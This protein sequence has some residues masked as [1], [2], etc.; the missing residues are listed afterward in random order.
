MSLFQRILIAPAVAVV[1]MLLIGLGQ[2]RAMHVQQTHLAGLAK[3]RLQHAMV[4]ADVRAAVLDTHT[5]AYRVLSWSGSVGA[6]YVETEA[7]LLMADLEATTVEFARWHRS[8]ALVAAEKAMSAPLLASA[9][10]YRQSLATGLDLASVD[11]ASGVAAMQ[12]A[13]ADFQRLA[14]QARDLVALEKQLAADA[15]AAAEAAYLRSVQFA[16]GLVVLAV[17]LAT[18]L[19][20]ATARSVIRQLGGEPAYAR[21]VVTRIADG[22]LTVQVST[23][24]GDDNSM[25]AAVKGMAA[26]LAGLVDEL[27]ASEHA[28]TRVAAQVA[29]TAQGLSQASATQVARVGEATAA[30]QQMSGSIGRNA[31]DAKITDQ[32]AARAAQE[33]IQGGSA[34]R[35]TVVA[36]QQIARKIGIVDDIAYQTNLLALNAAIE[37]ARAGEHGKGFSVVAAEVRKLAERSQEAAQEIGTLAGSSV[38]LAERAGG[39]LDDMLPSIQK[40]SELV[41]DIAAASQQQ[42]VGVSQFSVAMAQLNDA[43]QHTASAYQEMADTAESMDAQARQLEQL[44]AYFKVAR[45]PASARPPRALRRALDLESE[46]HSLTT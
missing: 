42:S 44:T 8:D 23:R 2:W 30:V 3:T 31:E 41:Q 29:G 13:D 28:L 20:I 21:D 16:V 10:K 17:L 6:S 27:R 35:E 18:G 24:I 1:L 32:M 34:V 22:D 11:V 25:L 5:R 9:D 26:R 7:E 4:A 14:Q 37:A 40:T 46:Q 45:G 19:G 36:M 43:T 15:V 12:T 38:Q 33:A 39:L